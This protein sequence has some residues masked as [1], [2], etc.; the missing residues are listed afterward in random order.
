MEAAKDETRDSILGGG[1][2]VIQPRRGY[3]FSVEA[4]LL[5]RFVRPR[6]GARILE[7]GAGCGVVAL[8]IAALFKPKEVVAVEVQPAMVALI[9][10]N[11]ELNGLGEVR[12]VCA[13]IRRSRLAGLAAGTFDLVVANPPFR[14]EGRGRE[15][16]DLGRRIARGA[17]GAGISDFA[18]AAARY[19][20]FGGT[21]AF[22]FS[23]AQSVELLS[24]LRS[25]ELEPKRI[26]FVHARADAEA[27]V[28]LV[29]AKRGGGVEVKV[30]PPLLLYEREG[31]YSEEARKHLGIPEAK[32][33]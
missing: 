24:L 4:I 33:L 11:A 1:L 16:P 20:R 8:I 28:V 21:A 12:A 9:R 25:H 2:T 6:A 5:A 22:V 13:D 14:A 15:S 18:S 29:E 10:R 3:R 26:R 31:V 32:P 27:S 19:T 30:E 17:G 23:A 7:L